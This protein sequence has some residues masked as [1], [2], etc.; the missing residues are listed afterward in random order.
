MFTISRT[1]RARVFGIGFAGTLSGILAGCAAPAAAPPVVSAG[2]ETIVTGRL[3]A[4]IVVI[5]PVPAP[6]PQSGG[7]VLAAMG[8][9]GAAAAGLSEIILRTDQG[10]VLSVVQ[11]DTTGLAPGGRVTVLTSPRL[12]IARPGYSTPTS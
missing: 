11:A 8:S 1:V 9:T 10:N 5:R 6:A 2:T 4:T 3:I 7:A 12:M